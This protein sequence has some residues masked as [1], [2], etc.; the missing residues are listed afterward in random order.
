[1][2]HWRLSAVVNWQ[3]DL[4]RWDGFGL[5][6]G[7][8]DM[9][10]SF[11]SLMRLN[12]F[13]VPWSCSESHSIGPPDPYVRYPLVFVTAH[14]KGLTGPKIVTAEYKGLSEKQWLVA[15]D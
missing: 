11:F 5:A 2:R 13:C 3:R 10:F 12:F 14:S 7:L 6:A 15:G 1:M 4:S 8:L 9:M